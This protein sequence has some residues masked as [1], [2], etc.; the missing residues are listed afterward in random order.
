[1]IS[2]VRI[3][4]CLIFCFGLSSCGGNPFWLPPAHKITIQ[5]GN[6][7]TEKQVSRIAVGMYRDDVRAVIGTPVARNSFQENR[8][9]YL[10]TQAPAG[11]VTAARNLTVFFDNDVVSKIESNTGDTSGVKPPHRNWWEILFPP[12][13]E[14]TRL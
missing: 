10:Y 5:Q 4:L 6:L 1:M 12:E 7:L 8:W 9:D 14:G 3:V 11:N 2:A 13:R